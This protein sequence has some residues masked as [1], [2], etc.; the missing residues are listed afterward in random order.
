MILTEAEAAASL[1][2]P[3]E[4]CRFYLATVVLTLYSTANLLYVE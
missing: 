1:S 3:R 4:A 2:T